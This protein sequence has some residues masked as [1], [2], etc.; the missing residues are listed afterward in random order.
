V[1]VFTEKKLGAKARL[2]ASEHGAA[3]AGDA[4]R[5]LEMEFGTVVFATET[6]WNSDSNAGAV[7]AVV[8]APTYPHG[9][10]YCC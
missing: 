3:R 9:A 10:A 5:R 2:H 1:T 8:N 7:T 6:R 4:G